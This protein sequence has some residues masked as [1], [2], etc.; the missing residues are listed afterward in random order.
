MANVLDN[1]GERRKG[2]AVWTAL[3]LHTQPLPLTSSLALVFLPDPGGGAIW[4][5]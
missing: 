3:P 2:S 5:Q 4:E 1:G